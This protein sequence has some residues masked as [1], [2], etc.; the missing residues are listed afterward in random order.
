M[1]NWKSDRG[2]RRGSGRMMG[3]MRESNSASVMS[4]SA[5]AGGGCGS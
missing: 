2:L 5:N 3:V 1:A 4:V